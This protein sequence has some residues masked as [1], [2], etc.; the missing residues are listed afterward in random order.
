MQYLVEPLL[1]LLKDV[2]MNYNKTSKQQKNCSENVWPG[3]H[4]LFLLVLPQFFAF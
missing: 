1:L 3:L 2:D 4:A